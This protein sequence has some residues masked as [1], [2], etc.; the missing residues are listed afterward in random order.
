MRHI[1][2]FAAFAFLNVSAHASSP[3]AWDA[4]YKSTQ[5]ACLQKSGL[6][7]AK[8]IEGPVLFAGDILYKIR[9][10]WPQAHMQGKTGKVYCLHP[11]PNGEPEIV[12]AR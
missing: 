2:V 9:G 4:L 6:K 10:K 11:Y 3:D 1:L 5:Q 7:N 12:D 8:L